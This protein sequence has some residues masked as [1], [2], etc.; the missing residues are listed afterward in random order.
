MNG[1]IQGLC[2]SWALGHLN[3]P[4]QSLTKEI[5]LHNSL[6]ERKFQQHKTWKLVQPKLDTASDSQKWGLLG[7][8]HPNRNLTI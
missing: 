6:E 1:Q 3:F 4:K 5:F 8:K 2:K 7:I